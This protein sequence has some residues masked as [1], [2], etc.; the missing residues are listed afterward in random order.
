MHLHFSAHV[1]FAA[2]AVLGAQLGYTMRATFSTTTFPAKYSLKPRKGCTTQPGVSGAVPA[3][4]RN[5]GLSMGMECRTTGSAQHLQ[6]LCGDLAGHAHTNA[7][8]P[9]LRPSLRSVLTPGWL[10]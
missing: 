6:W 2:L 10:C 7:I 4:M 8:N 1:E 9:G 5:P 3:A